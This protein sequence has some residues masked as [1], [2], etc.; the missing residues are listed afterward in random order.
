M[1]RA[2]VEV[3]NILKDRE[4]MSEDDGKKIYIE[5]EKAFKSNSQVLID[6]TGIESLTTAVINNS[7]AKYVEDEGID[8]VAKKIRISG[9]V[10]QNLKD[11]FNFSLS[12][13][14]RKYV[15]SKKN[16]I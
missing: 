11:I 14:Q 2:K 4:P 5:L 15:T 1:N 6:F 9:I 12:L 13:A 16:T 3:Y 10:D 8:N 7:I